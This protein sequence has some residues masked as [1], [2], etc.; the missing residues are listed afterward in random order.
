[1]QLV[2]GRREP[3]QPH[4]FT[5]KALQSPSFKRQQAHTAPVYTS[6]AQAARRP[7]AAPTYCLQRPDL[8]VY[9]SRLALPPGRPARAPPAASQPC[10]I[11]RLHSNFR[12]PRAAAGRAV[13]SMPLVSVS[14]LARAASYLLLQPPRAPRGAPGAAAV[15]RHGKRRPPAQRRAICSAAAPQETN[16][17]G[18]A[19]GI[20][21]DSGTGGGGHGAGGGRAGAPEDPPPE[22]LPPPP[23]PAAY[24]MWLRVSSRPACMCP[25]PSGTACTPF[26]WDACVH[27]RHCC[28]ARESC[29]QYIARAAQASALL[30]L[31]RLHSGIALSSLTPQHVPVCSHHA[32]TQPLDPQLP[33]SSCCCTYMALG[34]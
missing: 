33:P 13:T 27:R 31:G 23:P 12:Q 21:D 11:I 2:S 6:T 8:S 32:R 15:R 19:G 9:R 17:P 4:G 14:R 20:G 28:W 18:A 3:S 24:P 5:H 29:L 16:P 10:F 22:P 1:M 30:L 34:T 26:G 25:A 7:H